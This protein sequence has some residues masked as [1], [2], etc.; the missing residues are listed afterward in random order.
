MDPIN[1]ILIA[2]LLA[3]FGFSFFNNKKRKASQEILESNIKAGAVVVLISGILGTVEEVN[4]ASVLVRTG[5]S[6]IEVA[7]GSIRSAVPGAAK[8]AA[9]KPAAAKSAAKPAAKKPAAAKSAA[10]PAAK[11]P[12]VKKPA[13]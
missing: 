12:A 2:L 4:G 10:K 7:R 5:S 9:A 3:M 1:L 13:K 6:T 11:K 8:P